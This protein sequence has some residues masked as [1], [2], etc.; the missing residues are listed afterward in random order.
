[1]VLSISMAP[2]F[3][4]CVTVKVRPATVPSR[5][6]IFHRFQASVHGHLTSAKSRIHSLTECRARVQQNVSYGTTG[7]QTYDG[8]GVVC[9][10]DD[11]LLTVTGD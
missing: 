4:E 5:Y 7:R 3:H 2:P 9:G 1:M 8:F 11:S 10:L 6:A